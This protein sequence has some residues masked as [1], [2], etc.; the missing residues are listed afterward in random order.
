MARKSRANGTSDFF[1]VGNNVLELSGGCSAHCFGSLEPGKMK[2][3]E[4]ESSQNRSALAA[5]Q[6]VRTTKSLPHP[7]NRLE[8][9]QSDF[10]LFL[11]A[12][13]CGSRK[14]AEWRVIKS[15]LF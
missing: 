12:P 9:T 7:P 2:I 6:I 4:I 13:K 10:H 3:C 11:N 15:A 1:R 5:P 8:Q 14:H